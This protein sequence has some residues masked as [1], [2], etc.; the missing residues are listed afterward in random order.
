M[1]ICASELSAQE[2]DKRGKAISLKQILLLQERAGEQGRSCLQPEYP[3]IFPLCLWEAFSGQLEPFVWKGRAKK[4]PAN[5]S[6]P[7]LS[8][9]LFQKRQGRLCLDFARSKRLQQAGSPSPTPA[10][11]WQEASSASRPPL[12]H[13]PYALPSLAESSLPLFLSGK[14]NPYAFIPGSGTGELKEK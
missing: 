13:A 11:P 4:I 1:S 12:I 6:P 7:S 9:W 8:F 5:P 10:H 2:K 3:D 14:D